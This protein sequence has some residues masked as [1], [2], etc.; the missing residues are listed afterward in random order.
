MKTVMRMALAAA[1]AMSAGSASAAQRTVVLNVENV[2][3]ALCGPIVKKALSR[4]PGVNAVDVVEG[5]GAAT[6]TVTFDDA[7]VTVEA[8]S[9]ATTKA[10]Y[11]SRVKGN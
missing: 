3:C 8:L 5:P 4:L 1:V 6:A 2:T 10:G 9:D 11:P 7:K